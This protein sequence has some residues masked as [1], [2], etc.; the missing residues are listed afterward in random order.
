MG[1]AIAT[2]AY[3]TPLSYGYGL[4]ALNYGY[5]L[6]AYNGLYGAYNGILGGRVFKRE[7]EADADAYYGYAGYS[8]L[9]Y[10]GLGYGYSGL[11]Y[12]GAYGYAAPYAAR[13]YAGY[14]YAAPYAYAS[15]FGYSGYA[16]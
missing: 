13:A 5:G 12:A 3:T 16:W 4:G 14:G 6:N 9:G 10:A 8:G 15:R 1:A 11:G 2:T 7:A